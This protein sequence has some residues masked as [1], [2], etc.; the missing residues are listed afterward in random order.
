M[1]QIACIDGV[2]VYDDFAHHPSA[3][4][5][6]LAGLRAKV[7]E[8]RIVAIIEPRSNTMRMGYHDQKLLAA[9]AE[10]DVLVWHSESEDHADNLKSFLLAEHRPA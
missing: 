10:A 3:I 1:E 7:G 2:T 5:L 4:Q 6:T 9:T 8:A